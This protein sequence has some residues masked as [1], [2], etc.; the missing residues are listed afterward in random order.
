MG[1]LLF[2]YFCFSNK[3]PLIPIEKCGIMGYTKAYPKS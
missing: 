2:Y 3:N 1:G